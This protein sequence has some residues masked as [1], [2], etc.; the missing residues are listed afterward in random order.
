[1]QMPMMWHTVLE[2]VPKL[3]QE[4]RSQDFFVSSVSQEDFANIYDYCDYL[5]MN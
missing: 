4:T 3:E 2:A 5:E 1:M